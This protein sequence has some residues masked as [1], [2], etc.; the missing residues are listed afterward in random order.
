MYF[1]GKKQG[2]KFQRCIDI[3][4][5]LLCNG[6]SQKV[7]GQGNYYNDTYFCFFNIMQMRF[8]SIVYPSS[9]SALA[10]YQVIL[11]N[12]AIWLEES[13]GYALI[14]HY[15]AKD[16]PLPFY[17]QTSI[18]VWIQIYRCTIISHTGFGIN[19]KLLADRFTKDQISF[20]TIYDGPQLIYNVY[21]H[22]VA[23]KDIVVNHTAGYNVV[24]GVHFPN[25]VSGP[26]VVVLFYNA[27]RFDEEK[28]LITP[29]NVTKLTINTILD[30]KRNKPFYYRYIHAYT[31]GNTDR[32]LQLTV[33]N[34]T[35]MSGASY[36]CEFGGFALIDNQQVPRKVMGPYCTQTGVEPLV[37][38]INTFVSDTPFLYFLISTYS[39]EMIMNISIH[40]SKCEGIMNI[41]TKF[42]GVHYSS[43][44]RIRHNYKVGVQTRGAKSSFCRVFII[45][46][47]GC[48]VLQRIPT[49]SKKGYCY[50]GIYALNGVLGTEYEILNMLR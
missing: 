17:Y 44:N 6:D 19:F 13:L 32:F 40:V 30:R 2:H 25:P 24:Y 21:L 26:H 16:L 18:K 42:C 36:N 28:I 12:E 47:K 43:V 49:N 34:I 3:R 10:T 7:C 50:I 33:T 29:G 23:S 14:S 4:I 27:Y 15:D 35:W 46:E 11:R 5:L 45:L 48:I 8:Q 41:C 1:L 31:G 38:D 37:N 22:A 39:F 20:V 9:V